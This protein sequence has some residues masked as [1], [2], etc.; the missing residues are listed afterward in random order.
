MNSDEYIPHKTERSFH[1]QTNKVNDHKAP[2]FFDI[3]KSSDFSLIEIFIRLTQ[4][5][6]MLY[7]CARVS[8]RLT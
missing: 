5:S 7:G 8:M 1:M 2:M 6:V 3:L 4:T